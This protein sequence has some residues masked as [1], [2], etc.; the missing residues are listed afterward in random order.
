MAGTRSGKN[1]V[2]ED[3]AGPAAS[4]GDGIGPAEIVARSG[5]PGFVLVDV[6]PAVSYAEGH[7]PGAV[8]LPL[9]EI[10][11]RAREVLPDLDADVAVY[12]ASET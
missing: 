12:C 11:T 4:A 2:N 9:A 10:E 8:S 3:V 6:L 5:D 1:R 7:L